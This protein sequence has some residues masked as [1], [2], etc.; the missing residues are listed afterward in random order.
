[1]S[2]VRKSCIKTLS[3]IWKNVQ[4][5]ELRAEESTALK[6]MLLCTGQRQETEEARPKDSE[7]ISLVGELIPPH[8]CHLNL[9][10]CWGG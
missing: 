10:S 9:L 7:L 1:M 4:N 3:S 6:V 5:V 2:H 8:I